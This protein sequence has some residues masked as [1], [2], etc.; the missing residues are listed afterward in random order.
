MRQRQQQERENRERELREKREARLREKQKE[1]YKQKQASEKITA[2]Q[3]LNPT[4]DANAAT[5]AEPPGMSACMNS[6]TYLK[7][8]FLIKIKYW[9]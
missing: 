3:L 5:K 8:S 6:L 2:Q 4:P 1:D 9:L 7:E